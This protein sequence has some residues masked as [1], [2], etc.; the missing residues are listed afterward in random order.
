MGSLLADRGVER[1]RLIE[2]IAARG[3][4]DPAVLA[5]MREVPRE[6]FVPGGLAEFAYRDVALPIEAEQTISQPYLV[7]LMTQALEL[8]RQD[9]VLEIGTGSGYAAA[10]LSHVAGEVFTIERHRELAATARDRLGSLDLHNVMVRHG[11]GRYGWPE[12]APYDAI[13]VTAA[14]EMVPE[15]LRQQLAVGGRLL[16]PVGAPADVHELLR[17]R[18]TGPDEFKEESLEQVRFVPLLPGHTGGGTEVADDVTGLRSARGVPAAIT[19]DC[20]PFTDIE[21]AGLDGLLERIGDARLVLLGEASHGT[22]EF[23]RMRQRITRELIE[24]AGFRFVAVEADWPDAALVDAYVRRGTAADE[25]VRS[26]FRRFPLWMWRNTDVLEFV[27]WLREYNDRE[28]A[29]AVGFHGLDLYSMHDSIQRVLSY[30]DEMDPELA[31]TARRRY[32]CLTPYEADPAAYGMAAITGRYREC[33]RDV[34]T[35]LQEVC[36]RRGAYVTGRG[37]EFLDAEQNAAVARDAERYYRAMYYG[38][39]ESW[40][41]RDR[42]MFQTL[43]ALMAFHGPAAKAVVWAHNSHLGDAR[44]TAMSN[45]GQ[46]NLGQLVREQYG[47]DSYHVGFGTDHGTVLAASAWGQDPRLMQVRPGRERSYEQLF[48]QVEPDAFLLPLRGEDVDPRLRRSLEEERLERAIGVIYRPESELASHYFGAVLPAQ[49]DEY[50]WFDD[51]TAV[52]PLTGT[53]DVPT[54]VRHPFAALDT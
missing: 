54:D 40:N 21:S 18:R 48:H 42:H 1:T 43:Q 23:Y 27:D 5:A 14:A 49:F 37:E 29:H 28:P 44:A 2:A 41:I 46:I 10:V 17:V 38:G 36:R 16:I 32:G 52:T 6:L 8:T 51:T 20:E 7:A 35:V 13:V 15:R 39:Q 3:V 24:Q 22:S 30:L 4:T 31:D 12:Y 50:C 33:E 9:R 11:D 53:T 19:A 25:S 26:G 34:V 45:H 47:A